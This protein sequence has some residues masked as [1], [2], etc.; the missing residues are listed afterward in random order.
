MKKRA[1]YNNI[2]G[3]FH[4]TELE[5]AER[6]LFALKEHFDHTLTIYAYRGVFIEDLKITS[7][8]VLIALPLLRKIKTELFTTQKV[9]TKKDPKIMSIAEPSEEVE[10]NKTG[11]LVGLYNRSVIDDM[12]KNI[13]E[14]LIKHKI[15]KPSKK[16]KLTL[17][18]VGLVNE[19]N[20]N[21]Y[22]VSGKREEYLRLLHTHG[23]LHGKE[24]ASM[25]DQKETNLSQGI[26]EFNELARKELFIREDII[27]SNTKRGYFLN[28]SFSLKI[29]VNN[30]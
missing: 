23:S 15:S 10:I 5:K 11:R 17:S 25:V 4:I 18:G 22:P 24:F 13:Q 14:Y 1:D 2:L 12:L 7:A 20:G 16:S 21:V 30:S 9:P 28:K 3:G 29:L 26:K 6:V 8:E 19:S 27:E